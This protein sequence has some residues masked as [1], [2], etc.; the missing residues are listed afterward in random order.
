MPTSGCPKSK[1]VSTHSRLKAAG[2]ERTLL[3]FSPEVSTHSR[4]KAAGLVALGVTFASYVSTHSRL[5]A[6]G[7]DYSNACSD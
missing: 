6:A 7:F 5:K 4:L 1:P 2:P 3:A